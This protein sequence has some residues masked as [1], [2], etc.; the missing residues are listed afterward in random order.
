MEPVGVPVMGVG[1]RKEGHE[2]AER[3]PRDRVAAATTAAAVPVGGAAPPP[4]RCRRGRTWPRKRIR[5]V[6]SCFLLPGGR[7]SH[8]RTAETRGAPSHP[9]RGHCEPRDAGVK[10]APERGEPIRTA[11][12][13][14]RVIAHRPRRHRHRVVL[15]RHGRGVA[16][17][18]VRN[19]PGPAR[20]DAGHARRPPAGHARRGAGTALRRSTG[21]SSRSA[22]P[23]LRTRGSS[24][25]SSAVRRPVTIIT[26]AGI[27]GWSLRSESAGCSASRAM[28][29]S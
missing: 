14:A 5:T 26:S 22:R 21:Q 4:R 3:E 9:A 20:H 25:Y 2:R 11:R 7:T 17:V 23:K 29:A 6:A 10:L 24:R 28:R 18:S 13:P 16:R 19:A 15:P 12:R 8:S 1:D 27:P